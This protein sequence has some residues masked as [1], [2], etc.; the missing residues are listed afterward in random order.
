MTPPGAC[1]AGNSR[2]R[3]AESVYRVSIIANNFR[4]Y[5]QMLLFTACQR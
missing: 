5:K 3:L 2:A 4:D 1:Q